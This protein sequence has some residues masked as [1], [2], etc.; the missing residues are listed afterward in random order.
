MD[1]RSPAAA[2]LPPRLA[3]PPQASS[4]QQGSSG[5]CRASS[6]CRHPTGAVQHPPI[7]PTGAVQQP[8]PLQSPPA[9]LHRCSAAPTHPSHRCSAAASAVA[10]PRCPLN[11]LAPPAMLRGGYVENAS[12]AAPA[13][14][15]LAILA[16]LSPRQSLRLV[17][18]PHPMD[19]GGEAS[20][21]GRKT[22][23]RSAASLPPP[24]PKCRLRALPPS[25]WSAGRV[26]GSHTPVTAGRASSHRARGREGMKDL[27]AA[28]GTRTAEASSINTCGERRR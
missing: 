26:G 6:H 20:T 13:R 7:H 25:A 28:A 19:A 10:P 12:T 24:R 23:R 2:L 21:R 3:F 18:P 27:C 17:P 14:Y 8:P 16:S 1:A 11:R 5:A 4:D 9:S 15:P 22:P